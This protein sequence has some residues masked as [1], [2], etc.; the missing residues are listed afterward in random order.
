MAAFWS[1]F[2]LHIPELTWGSM[3]AP[4]VKEFFSEEWSANFGCTKEDVYKLTRTADLVTDLIQAHKPDC[5]CCRQTAE[6][7]MLDTA[8]KVRLHCA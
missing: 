5:N 1:L 6:S 8:S 2:T 7:T 3:G 4:A